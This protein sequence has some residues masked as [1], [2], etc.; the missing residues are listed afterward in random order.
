MHIHTMYI[1][2]KVFD[3]QITCKISNLA[4]LILEKI[5]NKIMRISHLNHWSRK[6]S[7]ILERKAACRLHR[8]WLKPE[9]PGQIL[10]TARATQVTDRLL[11]NIIF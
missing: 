1:D 6:Y 5:K 8:T 2:H 10:P 9:S 4:A 3:K 7:S 11:P